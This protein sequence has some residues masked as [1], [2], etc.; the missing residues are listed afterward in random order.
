MDSQVSAAL[1]DLRAVIEDT[2]RAVAELRA[3]REK[4]EMVEHFAKLL[5]E[6]RDAMSV[7]MEP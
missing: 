4:L 3:T 5:K 6:Q 1:A 7:G 2:R